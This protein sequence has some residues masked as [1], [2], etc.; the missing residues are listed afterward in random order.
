MD[1]Y[2]PKPIDAATLL[3]T[4]ERQSALN[5]DR[6]ARPTEAVAAR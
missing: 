6:L 2:V 4:I 5:A 3:S 1:D